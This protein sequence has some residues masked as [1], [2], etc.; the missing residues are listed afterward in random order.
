[1]PKY[2]KEIKTLETI[3]DRDVPFEKRKE[4]KKFLKA[5]KGEVKGGASDKE[6]DAFKG[7]A[8]GLGV[9]GEGKKKVEGKAAGG[10]IKSKATSSSTRAPSRKNS[11]LYGR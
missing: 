4:F 7:S 10:A 1:M 11:G 5:L 3:I 8:E 2:A 6:M 9:S